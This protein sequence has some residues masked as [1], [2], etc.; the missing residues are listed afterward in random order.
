[1]ED[2]DTMYVFLVGLIVLAAMHWIILRMSGKEIE[3]TPPPLLRCRVPGPDAGAHVHGVTR[4]WRFA[5]PRLARHHLVTHGGRTAAMYRRDASW[6]VVSGVDLTVQGSGSGVEGEGGAYVYYTPAQRPHIQS[7]AAIPSGGGGPSSS[8][9]RAIPSGADALVIGSKSGWD[10]RRYATLAD[11]MRSCPP[12]TPDEF[13]VI[14][15][16]ADPSY[17]PTF[18]VVPVLR[19]P[20]QG[21][22]WLT[23]DSPAPIY[24]RAASP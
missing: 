10:V 16:S 3:Q 9:F 13:Y 5:C 15:G 21:S 12:D 24:R 23:L 1:M 11:A 20:P 17:D 2:R 8:S 22:G 19:Q 7:G 18:Y 14:T 4:R 6:W